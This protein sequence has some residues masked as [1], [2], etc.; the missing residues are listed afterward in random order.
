MI[1]AIV[2][3]LFGCGGVEN[4]VRHTVTGFFNARDN[5][6][7]SKCLDYLSTQL[8]NSVGESQIINNLRNSTYFP[9]NSKLYSTGTPKINGKTATV[10]IDIRY[11]AQANSATYTFISKQIYLIEEST[12][13]K[14]DKISN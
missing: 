12:G 4:D 8:L 2:P 1:I 3:L 6:Q 11:R 14:I 5:Q 13:W 7:Y 10:W 9:A